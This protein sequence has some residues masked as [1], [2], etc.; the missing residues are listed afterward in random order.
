[1]TTLRD[2]LHDFQ[3]ETLELD[4]DKNST[5]EDFDNLIDEYLEQVKERLIG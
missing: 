5:K 3:L 4:Q 2:L 1:M